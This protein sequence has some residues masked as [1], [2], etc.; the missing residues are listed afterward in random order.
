MVRLLLDK[1]ADVNTQ[2]GEYSNALQAAAAAAAY[3]GSEA[4]VK[5]LL[6]KGADVNAQGGNYGNALQAAAYKGYEWIVKLLTE[7]HTNVN[8]EDFQG[9]LVLHFAIRG[10]QLVMIKYLLSIGVRANWTYADQ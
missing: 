8:R 6:D 2:G 4:V 3:Q 5:L 9:R 7:N 1:G 10:N